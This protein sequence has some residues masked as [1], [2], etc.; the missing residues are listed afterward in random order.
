MSWVKMMLKFV[1]CLICTRWQKIPI[2]GWF[3]GHARA[4]TIS[5][6]GVKVPKHCVCVTSWYRARVCH[7]WQQ[8]RNKRAVFV[9]ILS[10]CSQHKSK[11]ACRKWNNEITYG[12]MWRTSFGHSS[13]DSLMHF[14]HDYVTHLSHLLISE[15]CLKN[16]LAPNKQAII[17]TDDGLSYW[18]IHASIV[19]NEA[20][21]S[22]VKHGQFSLLILAWDATQFDPYRTLWCN[23]A[24]MT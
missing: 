2:H 10:L 12:W 5:E 21:S 24:T 3:T 22:P 9:F 16:D 6:D 11:I 17:W 15:R 20:K 1:L 4:R 19:L 23:Y 13:S 7:P 8:W 14:R 18:R